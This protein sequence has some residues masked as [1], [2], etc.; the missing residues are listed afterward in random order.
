MK[1]KII[2]FLVLFMGYQGY[3]QSNQPEN[4]NWDAQQI[5]SILEKGKVAFCNV[6]IIVQR[7]DTTFYSKMIK[8]SIPNDS[9]FIDAYLESSI[10]YD[11]TK[12]SQKKATC[13]SLVMNDK[14]H[15]QL[16]VIEEDIQSSEELSRYLNK[17]IQETQPKK[18]DD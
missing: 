4:L 5:I 16:E 8:L 18:T 3:S 6:N 13:I 12:E 7:N 9:I 10:L 15:G 17:R 1:T 2:F 14:W 11:N